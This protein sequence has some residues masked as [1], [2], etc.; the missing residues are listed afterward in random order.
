[1]L[2]TIQKAEKWLTWSPVGAGGSSVG[3]ILVVV[4]ELVEGQGLLGTI[5]RN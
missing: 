1:M 4:P 3:L 2:L 5:A